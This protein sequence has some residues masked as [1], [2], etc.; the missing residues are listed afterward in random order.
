MEKTLNC[1]CLWFTVH[2][3]S[4]RTTPEPADE[5]LEHSLT[6][7]TQNKKGLPGYCFQYGRRVYKAK[8]LNITQNINSL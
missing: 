8:I 3:I 2:L 4:S 6:K 1:S 7:C 5:A